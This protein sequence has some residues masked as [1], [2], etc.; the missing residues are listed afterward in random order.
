VA[1]VAASESAPA[2]AKSPTSA[3]SSPVKPPDAAA[4]NA[5]LDPAAVKAADTTL[6]GA[7]R[8]LGKVPAPIATLSEQQRIDESARPAAELRKQHFPTFESLKPAMSPTAQEKSTQLDQEKG[9]DKG[10]EGLPARFKTE[11]LAAFHDDT[12][13]KAASF[14]SLFNEVAKFGNKPDGYMMKGKPLAAADF[15]AAVPGDQSLARVINTDGAFSTYLQDEKAKKDWLKDHPGE[16][17]PPT[18]DE[19]TAWVLQKAQGNAPQ[20]IREYVKPDIV[21][22]PSWLFPEPQIKSD[23]VFSQYC[24]LLA[25]YAN[26]YPRGHLR[27]T[28]KREAVLKKIEGNHLRKPTVFDGTLSPLWLQRDNRDHNWGKTGGGL[29]EALMKVDWEEI[30]HSKW[31]LV[32]I[33]PKYQAVLAA[34]RAKN[35]AGAATPKKDPNPA[36]VKTVADHEKSMETQSATNQA[37][38]RKEDAGADR[39]DAGAQPQNELTTTAAEPVVVPTTMAGAA[40]TLKAD[41][42]SGKVEFNSIAGFAV[43]KLQSIVDLVP[44]DIRQKVSIALAK[45]VEAATMVAD[46]ALKPGANP[47][48]RRALLQKLGEKLKELAIAIRTFG[49]TAK[50]ADADPAA[51][52][53]ARAEEDARLSRQAQAAEQAKNETKTPDPAAAQPAAPMEVAPTTSN[54]AASSTA[55]NEV[56]PTAGPG[57][58]PQPKEAPPGLKKDSVAPGIARDTAVPPEKGGGQANDKRTNEQ[59][60]AGAVANPEIAPGGPEG[61]KVADAAQRLHGDVKR[62]S[63]FNP[64]DKVNF[65]RALAQALLSRASLYDA[66]VNRVSS[67]IFKYFEDRLKAGTAKGVQDAKELYT[68]DLALLTQNSGPGWWGAVESAAD[69]TVEDLAAQTRVTL[70]KGSLPQKMAVHQNMCGILVD[71]FKAGVAQGFMDAATKEPWYVRQQTKLKDGLLDQ[72]QGSSVF[73]S[74]TLNKNDPAA[75]AAAKAAEDERGRVKRPDMGAVSP[76]APGIEARD[77]TGADPTSLLPADKQRVNRGIDAFT[78]DESKAFCQRARLQFNMPLAAGVS[79]STAELI[80][81]AMTLGLSGEELQKYAIAVLAYI[82]GGGNHS[83]LE[84]AVVLASA[85]LIPNPVDYSGVETLVG[86][87]LFTQLKNEHPGAFKKNEPPPDGAL[88]PAVT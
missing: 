39:K 7:F 65:E 79:G 48:E 60:A 41:P 26:W 78:M 82:G 24:D 18:A 19:V 27:M 9:L 77:A 71:D 33:D 86:S 51:V 13:P 72:Q 74:P 61:E 29:R 84:I 75:V 68:R 20:T 67:L 3:P 30:D 87:T 11:V 54:A 81:V 35:A 45:A 53:S 62:D 12:H 15:N 25:L 85:G 83:Y 44:K 37:A 31:V 38:Q 63:H 6:K 14:E 32:T 21:K 10:L 16:T 57:A 50:I 59:T 56:A 17:V 70:T 88:P 66:Q 73:A 28:V 42:A 2:V 55:A 4:D 69:A 43:E 52:Q 36:D 49:D 23:A 40:H 46:P 22:F 1:P 58:A 5:P 8:I 34:Q 64:V 76:A 80:N 47:E